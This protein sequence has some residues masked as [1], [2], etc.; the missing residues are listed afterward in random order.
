M[1]RPGIE[2]RS[3]R[4]LLNTLTIVVRILCSVTCSSSPSK[5]FLFDLHYPCNSTII[6]IFLSFWVFG[7]SLLLFSVDMFPGRLQVFFV[8]LDSLHW[9][10]GSDSVNHN[11][12]NKGCHLEA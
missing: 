11:R 5:Y 8:E 12:V 6:I 3:T 1:T 10:A 4:P 7:P 2:P 9:V